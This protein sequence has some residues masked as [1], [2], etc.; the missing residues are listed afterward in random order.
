MMGDPN[1]TAISKFTAAQNYVIT[2][3][4][5]LSGSPV[6]NLLKT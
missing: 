2:I 1:G 5:F 3:K 4:A 6:K